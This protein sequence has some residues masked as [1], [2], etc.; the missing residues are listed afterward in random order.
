MGFGNLID[1]P[2]QNSLLSL[3]QGVNLLGG[4]M[5]NQAA[6]LQASTLQQ[7]ASNVFLQSQIEASRATVDYKQAIGQQA[8]G[9]AMGGVELTGSPLEMLNQTRMLGEQQVQAINLRGQLE[10]NLYLA[11]ANIAQ[12]TGLADLLSA[13]GEN[14]ISAQQNAISQYQQKQQL[15][16]EILNPFL[17]FGSGLL[18]SVAGPITNYILNQ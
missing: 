4:E 6:Q 16:Q 13:E 5:Q 12:D 10:Q 9:Y 1:A 17:S 11:Q 8:E 14:Q 2:A 15:L 3:Q 7:Q 18:D